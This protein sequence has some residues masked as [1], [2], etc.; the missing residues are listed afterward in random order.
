MVCVIALTPT[1]T[2]AKNGKNTPYE[3]WGSDQSNSVP[4]KSVGTDGSFIWIWSSEDMERQIRNGAIA[5]P[6]GC[7]PA[8]TPGAGPC[9]LKQVFPADLVQDA[10]LVL[11]GGSE[12]VAAGVQ[13]KKGVEGLPLR[14][15]AAQ[16][17]M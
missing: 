6:M 16:A 5:Q 4:G 9:D 11:C 17:S 2:E 12:M 13:M 10:L 1:G 3:I 7:D 8:N 15:A 14:T